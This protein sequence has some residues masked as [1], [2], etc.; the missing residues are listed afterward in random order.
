MTKIR[1]YSIFFLLV[2]IAASPVYSQGR[3]DI[4]RV[5]DFSTFKQLQTHF[6]FTEGPVWN[7]AGFLLFSDIPANRI[8]KWEAGKESEV[9]R[10]PSHNSNGL[11]YDREGRLIACEHGSRRVTRTLQDGTI[12]VLAEEYDGKKL[13]SPNDAVVAGDGTIYFTDPP[14]GVTEEKRELDFQGVYRIDPSG[15]LHLEH[16]GL[17]RPNGIGLSPDGKTLYVA[18]TN[19][20]LYSF[21]VQSNGELS[22][23]NK[24]GDQPLKGGDGLSVDKEGNIWATGTGGVWVYA[25][26]GKYI[27]RL[28][29]PEGPANCCFGG[30][31]GKDLYITARTSLYLVRTKVEGMRAME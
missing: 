11:T 21:D 10:D 14:Y 19:D 18:D 26:D 7:T 22:D 9:F 16:K 3:G 25:S 28:D 4:D 1:A 30:K 8:Y 5:V 6:K 23:P 31:D 12:E 24:F 15:D 2:L 13:N 27:G 17:D 20:Q 29:T